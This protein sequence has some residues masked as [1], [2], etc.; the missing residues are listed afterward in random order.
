MFV[1]H[2]FLFGNVLLDTGNVLLDITSIFIA[3]ELITNIYIM[4]IALA[5]IPNYGQLPDY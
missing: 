3:S 4:Y 2:V 1:I 5:K